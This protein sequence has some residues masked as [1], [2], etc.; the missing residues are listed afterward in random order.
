MS[1]IGTNE[2]LCTTKITLWNRYGIFSTVLM[3]RIY[4]L[5][6]PETRQ[7]IAGLISFVLTGQDT[8]IIRKLIFQAEFESKTIILRLTVY[9]VRSIWLNANILP[10]TTDL[11]WIIHKFI[12][13]KWY[14]Y[15]K[16][17]IKN[18][19]SLIPLSGTGVRT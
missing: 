1:P 18:Q 13:Y 17:L 3:G 5:L 4:I 14:F 9:V 6:L 8:L 15:H 7:W 16:Q 19:I 10:D 2:R 11:T 12:D